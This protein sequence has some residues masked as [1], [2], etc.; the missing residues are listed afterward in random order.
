MGYSIDAANDGCYPGTS[1]LVNKLDIRDQAQLEEN[2]TL[3][4]TF[5]SLQFELSPFPDELDFSHYKRLHRFLFERLYDWSGEIRSINLSKLHTSFCPADEIETLAAAS[6]SRLKKENYFCG[7]RRTA[8]LDE[9]T[10]F[11]LSINYLHPFREGN[12]RVQRLYFRELAKRAGYELNFAAVD[13]DQMMIATIHAASG[14]TDT[15]R[16]VFKQIIE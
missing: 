4:T 16:Q 9:L 15:L 6:F 3:I 14:I 2:E 13:S 5:Q 12:G 1:V 11:Y 7:L 10:D 8:F